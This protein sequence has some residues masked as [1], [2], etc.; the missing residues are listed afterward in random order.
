MPLAEDQN[1]IQALAPKCSDEAF[2]IR[3]L[4]GRPQ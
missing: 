1:V 3:I 4:P 2:G